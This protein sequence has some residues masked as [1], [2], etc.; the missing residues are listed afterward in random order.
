MNPDKS[1]STN[2]LYE[3]GVFRLDKN[4]GMLFVGNEPVKVA[5]KVFECLVLFV[6]SG[7]KIITKDDFFAEIWK[8]VFVEDSSLSYTISQLRKTL[9]EYDAENIY[10]ETVPRRGFRF[11]A[12]VRKINRN[13]QIAGVDEIVL[14]RR[15]VEEVWI[16][17]IEQMPTDSTL[18]LSPKPEKSFWKLSALMAIL[19][20]G[21][22]AFAGSIWYFQKA[23]ASDEINSIAVL[24]LKTLTE[25]E[26]EKILAN[27][28][29]ENIVSSL[30]GLKNLRV[31]SVETSEAEI[32]KLTNFDAALLGTIQK[33]DGKVRVS[34]RLLKISDTK[35]IWSGNFNELTAD[36]FQ[37]QDKISAEI[38]KSLSL[39]LSAQDREAV[40][41]H[42]TNNR[43]AYQNY[44]QGRYFFA[45]RGDNYADS[46][47][48]AKPFFERA[49]EL[50]PNFAEAYIGLADT[51]NLMTDESA[52]FDSTFDEGYKKAEKLIS[53]A[54]A[55]N[56]NLAEAHAAQGW[57]QSRY[58]WNL[59]EAEKSLLKA[60]ELNPNVPNFYIWLASINH[61]RGN[62]KTGIEFSQ[63]ALELDPTF[64]QGIIYLALSYAYDGQCEKAVELF[65][66]MAQYAEDHAQKLQ[67]EG[68]ILAMCGRCQEAVPAL[69][70][71]KKTYP[72]GRVVAFSLGDC[73]ARANQREQAE[74]ELK[75]LDSGS[76]NGN[77]V[78]GKII[79]FNALGE[80]E[81]ALDLFSQYYKMKNPRLLK[82]NFDPRL[83]NLRNTP[84]YKQLISELNLK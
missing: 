14:E 7:G 46:L 25:N 63:K 76:F 32:G 45:R 33:T 59:P 17:E 47:K 81:K 4:A 13:T 53:K 84:R 6:K 9:A 18:K 69:L 73:Y 80:M 83:K 12:E 62:L 50:D 79:I 58:Y 64:S 66:R 31:L 26:D 22:F 78:L 82:I 11:A 34:L 30:G 27:G 74:A 55:I 67:N 57:I 61:Y 35:Q 40:F 41:K 3:F 42:E 29:R 72:N 5:P 49:I 39:N 77:T 68:N 56:P 71:A 70:E 2:G 19:L 36:V 23:S 48:K 24:P 54:L 16:D 44:L 15:T 37:L 28:I 75:I 10:V 52:K 43:E 60:V 65:P 38:T 51:I 8:D 1:L 20:I 21:I